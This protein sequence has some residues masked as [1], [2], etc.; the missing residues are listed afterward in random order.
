[1]EGTL[2]SK[3]SKEVNE[4]SLEGSNNKDEND[5]VLPLEK[6][7]SPIGGGTQVTQS[8]IG[9]IVNWSTSRRRLDH[10][11]QNCDSRVLQVLTN[12]PVP[13]VLS[14]ETRPNEK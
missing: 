8:R 6:T 13:V 2:R 10:L 14:S 11:L 1:M 12:W 5:D 4:N 3:D 7:P 9:R